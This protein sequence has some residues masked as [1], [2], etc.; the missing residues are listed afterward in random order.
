MSDSGWTERGPLLRLNDLVVRYQEQYDLDLRVAVDA[1]YAGRDLVGGASMELYIDEDELRLQPVRIRLPGG[2]LDAQ[3]GWRIDDGRMA[4][5]LKARAEALVYGGL[6]R[7]IDPASESRGVLYLDIDV[8]AVADH[9]ADVSEFE[10]LLSNA[11]GIIEI[12][13]WPENF[14]AGVLDL[15][16]ANLVFALLPAPTDGKSARLNCVVARFEAEDGLLTSKNVLMDSTRTIIRGRG[17]IDLA[18]RELDLLVTPQAK[19][20]KFFS[21]STPVRVTGPLEDFQVGVE[22]AGFLGTLLKWYTS[23]IYVPFKWL[24]GQRF[25]ADGTQTCFDAMDWELTPELEAYFLK[26]DFSSPPAV[27]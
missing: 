13:A 23:L 15:W 6:L 22:P 2:G 26:R 24:T 12:A 10:L 3:Y 4:G 19:R 16:T 27:R 9:T 20:E 25:P 17:R 7:L 5:E 14:E 11:D 21:A 1:L 18:Q 8:R